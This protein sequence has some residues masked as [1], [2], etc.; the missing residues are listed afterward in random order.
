MSSYEINSALVAREGLPAPFYEPT[1]LPI[2]PR[3]LD[4]IGEECPFM[5]KDG[6]YPT[7]HH[8]FFGHAAYL[9][10]GYP[11]D[12][13]VN[14]PHAIKS[15]MAV[16]RH[17]SSVPNAW[18][19][20]YGYARLPREEVAVRFLE[21]SATLQQLSVLITTMSTD[22]NS[23]FDIK[24]TS[25][26]EAF[27]E[28]KYRQRL[29]RYEQHAQQYGNALEAIGGIEVMPSTI[30]GSVLTQLGRRRNELAARAAQV[31]DLARVMIPRM[32]SM[33]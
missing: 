27:G 14:D 22:I 20:L 32:L 4:C 7:R 9:A 10:L 2:P 26:W 25:R 5:A 3:K 11:Y 15:G 13:L 28:G 29:E 33:T 17:N 24:P 31:P 19:N 6:C 12:E 30:V 16:C 18:H 1:L 8:L 21:E 23:I